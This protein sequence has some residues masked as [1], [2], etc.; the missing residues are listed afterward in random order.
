MIDDKKCLFYYLFIYLQD[1]L[2]NMTWH[3]VQSRLLEVQ[4]EQQMCIHKIELTELGQ[5]IRKGVGWG[6]FV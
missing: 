4:K 5:C 6:L 3:E 1:E 2:A